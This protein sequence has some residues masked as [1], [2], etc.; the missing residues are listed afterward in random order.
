MD[1]TQGAIGL[2]GA[3]RHSMDNMLQAAG[4][5][6]GV[7]GASS[8]SKGPPPPPPPPPPPSSA[9]LQLSDASQFP[10]L[11]GGG[12]TSSFAQPQGWRGGRAADES[13]TV[14]A[15]PT[16]TAVPVSPSPTAAQV[17]STR[18]RTATQLNADKT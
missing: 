4:P 13:N 14:P 10:A 9:P 3:R 2:A 12:G 18:A 11:G 7:V 1:S 8:S 17:V 15:A 16:S 6:G 5:Q